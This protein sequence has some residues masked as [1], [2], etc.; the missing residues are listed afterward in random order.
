MI[1][2]SHISDKF[3]KKGAF[4][5]KVKKEQNQVGCLKDYHLKHTSLIVKFQNIN[6][7]ME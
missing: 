3:S 1:E 6:F 5:L 2:S 7:E 4:Q